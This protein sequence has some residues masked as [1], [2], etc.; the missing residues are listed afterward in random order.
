MGRKCK[1]FKTHHFSRGNRTQQYQEQMLLQA[2]KF[3]WWANCVVLYNNLILKW[4]LPH[5]KAQL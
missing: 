2:S 4:P 3:I 1:Y 5:G